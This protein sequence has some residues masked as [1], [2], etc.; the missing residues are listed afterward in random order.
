MKDVDLAF[1]NIAAGP[2]AGTDGREHA[3]DG[4]AG[5]AVARFSVNGA[6]G[7]A[8]PAAYACAVEAG[9]DGVVL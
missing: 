1:G 3:V 5:R 4:A 8:C 9:K 7:R 2:A 6:C